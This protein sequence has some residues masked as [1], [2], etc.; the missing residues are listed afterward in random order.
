MSLNFNN[1]GFP[2]AIELMNKGKNRIVSLDNDSIETRGNFSDEFLI[3]T[4]GR[5]AR[6][7]KGRESLRHEL[8]S[9]GEN[10]INNE[11][12]A[13]ENGLFEVLPPSLSGQLE[14]DVYFLSGMSGSGKTFFA[15]Q[16]IQKYR[17]AGFKKIFVIS[18]IDEENFGKCHYLDIEDFVKNTTSDY[19]QQKLDYETQKIKFKH[20]KK[21][22]EPHQILEIELKLNNKKPVKVGGS[23]Y[24][25]K[26]KEE[27]LGKI[28]KN[29]VVV[30]DDYEN[31][32]NKVM[33][34]LLRDHLLTKGRHYET[35][36][37]ICN[38]KTNGGITFSLIKSESTNLVLFKK[39][40]V[41]TRNILFKDYLGF[42]SS[43]LK[44]VHRILR[45]S[46]WICYN[47]DESL[48]LSQKEII[49]TQ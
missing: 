42:D 38:H 49:L 4:F 8:Q 2:V 34:E 48:I 40:N 28:F 37:I 24:E 23:K 25:L 46:R 30:F 26:F 15:C 47:L 21:E 18:D 1:Q 22:L 45:K 39:S 27:H 5:K 41:R 16:L 29:S 36:M 31:N 44:R 43:Q 9:E 20:I 33:I 6:T 19:H 11:V 35:N 10:L 14:R 17:K 3:A 13:S 12:Q 32:K 7:Q